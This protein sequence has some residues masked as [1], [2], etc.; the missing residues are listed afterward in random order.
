MTV[1]DYMHDPR[2]LSDPDMEGALEP[3]KEI[4]AARLKI[5]D[6]TSDMTTDDEE[7]AYHKNN[8][9]VLF[10]SKGRPSPQFVNFSGQGKLRARVAAGNS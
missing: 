6:E 8:L 2:L 3:V 5:Q 7:A 4:H 9:D 1:Q 10:S